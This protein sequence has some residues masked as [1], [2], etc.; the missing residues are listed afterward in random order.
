VSWEKESGMKIL[1]AVDPSPHTREAIRFV[2][3]VDW[4]KKSEIYLIHAIE[5]KNA[6][7]LISSD[8]LS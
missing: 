1:V 2:K 8:G 4:P 6:P 7:S 3:S 5:L